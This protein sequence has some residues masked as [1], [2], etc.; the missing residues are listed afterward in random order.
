MPGKKS[1]ILFPSYEMHRFQHSTNEDLD[2]SSDVHHC[3]SRQCAGS[4]GSH[5]YSSPDHDIPDDLVRGNALWLDLINKQPDYYIYREEPVFIKSIVC[6]VCQII[7][8]NA[9]VYDLGPGSENSI[10]AKTFPFLSGF[11]GLS[12]YSPFDISIDFVAEAERVV[13]ESFPETQVRGYALNFQKDPLPVEHSENGVVLYLGSTISNLPGNLHTP[14]SKNK[15]AHRELARLRTLLGLGGHLILLHDSNQNAEEVVR[16][17][18]NKELNALISNVLYRIKR[19]L[20]TQNFDP[21]SFSYKVRWYPDCSLLAHV[22]VSEC[23][24]SFKINGIG[25]HLEKGEEL[26]PVNSYKPTVGDIAK[27]ATKCGFE[28][29]RTFTCSKDRLALHVMIAT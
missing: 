2:F 7:D 19:D 11:S 1:E 17:Y 9:Y 28:I 15:A 25:Y 14:F 16:S 3:F 18:N 10:K 6:D 22:F 26:F 8:E 4:L 20:P 21:G 24:Q 12:G 27:I 23:R 5:I 29:V 13:R